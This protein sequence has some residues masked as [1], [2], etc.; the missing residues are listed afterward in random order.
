MTI[1]LLLYLWW[2]LRMRIRK[3][4][5]RVGWSSV[6]SRRLSLIVLRRSPLAAAVLVVNFGVGHEWVN[7]AVDRS[8][9]LSLSLFLSLISDDN[10]PSQTIGDSHDQKERKADEENGVCGRNL[11]HSY[12]MNLDLVSVAVCTP[13]F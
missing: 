9:S 11:S 1:A 6:L 3:A 2:C 13:R 7:R 5:R 8:L 10:N 4:L 12:V